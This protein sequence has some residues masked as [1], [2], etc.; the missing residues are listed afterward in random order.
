MSSAGPKSVIILGAT[1][2]I[3]EAA[4]RIWAS[5]GARL[6]LAA[7]NAERLQCIAADLLAR[8][9]AETHTLALD[10]VT[11][12]AATELGRMVELVGSVDV[13]LLAYGSLGDHRL[14]ERDDQAARSLFEVNFT[15]VAQWCLAAANLI[16]LQHCGVL[17]VIGS[18][19]GDRG[20][21]SNYIYGAAK[22]GIAAL[23]QGLAHRLARSGGRAVLLKP[24]LV[25]TPMTSQF[26]PKGMAW[27]QPQVIG[28]AIV[29]AADAGRS[30]V[31]APWWWRIIML[32][33]RLLPAPIFHKT[34]L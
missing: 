5:R 15:S 26:E 10:L 9:A 13:V 8:G 25:D 20:R 29:D 19:A 31:Y 1:S 7:R 32:I 30:I 4:A 27:S 14:A 18:V 28:R 17:V 12:P 22:A 6:I 34:K 16:E 3:A 2:A 33:I 24:G 21:Q 23:T 11:S